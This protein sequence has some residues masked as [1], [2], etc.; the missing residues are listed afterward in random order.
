MEQIKDELNPQQR[1]AVF[2]DDGPLLVIAGPGSGKTH[3]LTRRIARIITET[4]GERFRLLALTFTNKAADE[5]KERVEQLV[6]DE[7]DR[8]FISTFHGFCFEVLRKYGSYIN[9]DNNFTIYDQSANTN[10]Y[11]AL[12]IEAIQDE[13]NEE[14]S[15]KNNVLSRYENKQ[16]LKND[17]SKLLNAIFRLKNRLVT[18][19]DIPHDSRKYD[20]IFR[21][22]YTLYNK[23][24][25]DNNVIDFSDLL[26]LTYQL[27]K[28]KPFIAKQYRKTFKHL[29]I[30]EAQ[31]TNKAQFE[32]IKALCGDN[33]ENIFIVA[34]EDQLIY[35]WNDARFE[36]LLEFMKIYKARTVQMFENYRCPE[37]I[38]NMANQLIKLNVNRL[39]NK[40]DLR[41]NKNNSDN[42]VS[43]TQYDTPEME[44]ESITNEILKVND[45]NNTCVI[46][47]NRFILELIEEDLKNKEI[48][49]NYPSTSERFFT[50]EVQILIALLYATFNEEDTV[51]IN[52]VCDYF[53][54]DS[55]DLFTIEDQTRFSQFIQAV[56]EQ[57]PELAKTLSKLVQQKNEFF[58]YIDKIL[59]NLTN[60]SS[61]NDHPTD[62]DKDLFDDYKQLKS[63]ERKYRRER[64]DAEQNIGDFLNYLALS[65]KGNPHQEGVTLLT[66]HAAKG[67]EFDYVFV[68]SVNQGIFPDYRSID[69]PRSLEEERRNFFVAI[70]R[71]KK[72]LYLSYTI[73]RKTRF[74]YRYHEPSQFL[75]EVG[76]LD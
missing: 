42:N 53:N 34:D 8:L 23:K 24:L 13:L 21:T 62:K 18:P 52:I 35:E 25:R 64:E 20:K 39:N 30:D 36:Y 7:V 75:F 67:L 59:M 48:P 4:S 17:A 28:D 29:L 2:D 1:E 60:I 68:A 5:M 14:F 55:E 76:L 74:S 43:L 15:T 12:L 70:T 54:L 69:N 71:T 11:I 46:A 73:Q 47:R 31:D 50:Q 44:S 57:E 49:F 58:Y 3:I 66:G 51:N 9:L 10:N 19:E 32:I 22:V 26:L 56:T 16:V 27:F 38:L 63:I 61:F 6:G 65:P 45:F 40:K 37:S 41:A 33:Y 72:K